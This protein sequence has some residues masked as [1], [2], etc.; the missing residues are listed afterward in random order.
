MYIKNILKILRHPL[1]TIEG[2][3]ESKT[4][5]VQ[6]GIKEQTFAIISRQLSDQ[7]NQLNKLGTSPEKIL[8]KNIIVSLTTY[9]K[10]IN[11]VYL[12]I[13]SIMRQT[14]KP[15]KIL[16]WLASDEFSL[17]TIP[18]SVQLQ[19]KRGLEIH[20]CEDLLSYKKLI[21][22]LSLYEDD[23]IITIDDDVIYPPN[24]LDVL[25]TEHIKHPHD[26][27]CTRAR[28]I[29]FNETNQ[30]KPYVE[31]PYV[32]N[33]QSIASPLFVAI[34]IG[35]VLY[36]PHSLS[37]SNLDGKNFLETAPYADDL[38]FKAMELEKNICCRVVPDYLNFDSFFIST[39]SSDDTG[40]FQKNIW[41]N[42][43]Q[44]Q[45]ILK[46]FHID[47]KK[48]KNSIATSERLNSTLYA[49]S[50]ED[51]TLFLKHLYAYELATKYIKKN[52]NVLEIGCGTGYGT[53]FLSKTGAFIHAIDIDQETILSCA[54]QYKS[55]NIK[56]DVYNGTNIDLPDKSFDVI[57]SFQVIEHVT[58][59]QIFLKNIQRLLKPE[60]LF[61]I[62][63]PN[64]EYRLATNQKPWNPFHLRE[65]D[66]E[67]LSSLIK[68]VY[69]NATVLSITGKK[70]LVTIEKERVRIARADYNPKE[71][72]YV[73][74]PKDFR[75][76]YSTKNFFV[77]EKVDDNTLDLLATNASIM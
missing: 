66:K 24:F 1:Q 73:P 53:N 45:Q 44:F 41:A 19:Q 50:I 46:T 43:I 47:I 26:I 42:D 21:P 51:Y 10:R 70:E 35:G 68:Q 75:M 52:D 77:S 7:T 13:E 11:N 23:V 63:T 27:I 69:P 76:R 36:P 18:Q 32:I 37:L 29:Q 61:F 67:S 56:F 55:D 12:T 30:L 48:I 64:R 3:V 28:E 71:I 40:L 54:E 49:N 5:L 2:I 58:Q 9:G 65:Y 8:T 31:W 33:S 22:S 15:N 20:F 72:K 57:I 25:I 74:K 38:W 17:G 14:I 6:K 59:E 16:L 62:T 34:G 39:S 60:G 4:S